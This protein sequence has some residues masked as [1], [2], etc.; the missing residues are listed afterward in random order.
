[1]G[2]GIL[3]PQARR[4]AKLQSSGSNASESLII[5]EDSH[6]SDTLRVFFFRCN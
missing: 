3:L 5:D 4:K 6:M 2:L 1:M